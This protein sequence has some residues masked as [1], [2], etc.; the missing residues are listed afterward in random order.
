VRVRDRVHRER[1]IMGAR[2]GRGGERERETTRDQRL[3]ERETFVWANASS[4]VMA[5]ISTTLPASSYICVHIRPRLCAHTRTIM[6]TSHP[7]SL[8][9]CSGTRIIVT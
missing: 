7:H 4:V 5:P 8:P 2:A 9:P 1:V 6:R 3:R